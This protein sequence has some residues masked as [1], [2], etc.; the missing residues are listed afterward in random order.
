M[1]TIWLQHILYNSK[2]TVG[3]AYGPVPKVNIASKMTR[4]LVLSHIYK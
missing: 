3:I 1:H 2:T 4:E